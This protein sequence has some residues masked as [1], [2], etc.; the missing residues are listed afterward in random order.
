MW[1]LG[2]IY[3]S[4]KINDFSPI[5]FSSEG[6]AFRSKVELIAYFQKIGDT[7]TDPNDFDFTVTGRGCPSRREKRLMKKPNVV[8]PV[9]R[10]R[11]RPKGSGKRRHTD[12]VAVKRVIEESPGKLLVKMPLKALRA[13][14]DGPAELSR[15]PVTKKRRGRKR[16]TEQDVQTA[17]KKRGRKPKV[18]TPSGK[19]ISPSINVTLPVTVHI[20]DVRLKALRGSSAK[21]LQ[22]TA[23]PIK[24]RKI[25]EDQTNSTGPMF[26][27]S[28][29]SDKQALGSEVSI[30]ELTEEQ[31][32]LHTNFPTDKPKS[33]ISMVN[34]GYVASS[35]TPSNKPSENNQ[36]DHLH[37][38][39]HNYS[40][41]NQ[42]HCPSTA[43]AP[44]SVQ[45]AHTQ[46]ALNSCEPQDLSRPRPYQPQQLTNR[47]AVIRQDHAPHRLLS[48]KSHAAA[49][50][51]SEPKTKHRSGGRVE[52]E[53]Q[54]MRNAVAALAVPRL[55]QEET[56][57]PTTS[58][59]E[60]LS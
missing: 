40:S 26:S 59:T 35:N 7:N 38:H 6:K 43:V 17:S 24:K 58:V 28:R 49:A 18:T 29:R 30:N 47:P 14:A 31:K 53:E 9:G 54:E 16:K 25:M 33:S 3:A 50:V 36:K 2:L 52:E 4:K 13:E 48:S 37:K 12:G 22:E 44:H 39:Q 46:W 5:S 57:E 15:V 8:K 34:R 11:G 27:D 42:C 32:I 51:A 21:S 19:I 55:N 1:L 41:H 56:V 23:L 60:Q 45:H 20:T 10:R